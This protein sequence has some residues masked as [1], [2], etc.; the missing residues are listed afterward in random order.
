MS[1]KKDSVSA[2][3]LRVLYCRYGC[4]DN[5]FQVGR[6]RRTESVA[7]RART[8]IKAKGHSRRLTNPIH[9]FVF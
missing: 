3:R 8:K 7:V 6:A 1:S 5:L 4:Y 9:V 2:N